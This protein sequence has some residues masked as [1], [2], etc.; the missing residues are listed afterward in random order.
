MAGRQ[1]AN[2]LRGESEGPAGSGRM[3]DKERVN[4][5]QAAGEWL[6]R[7]KRRAGRARAHAGLARAHAGLARGR[8]WMSMPNWVPQSP[9][10]FSR[11]TSTPQNSSVLQICR[12]QGKAD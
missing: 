5:R 3:A 4:G 12:E 8:T 6:A 10:W 1:R 9:M 2:G 11:T 7:R